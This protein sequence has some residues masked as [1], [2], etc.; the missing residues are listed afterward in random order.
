MGA[1]LILQRHVKLASMKVSHIKSFLANHKHSKDLIRFL[2]LL[3]VLVIYFGYLSWKYDLAT[4]GIVSA[5]TW[6]FFVLCTPI[7]DAGFLIDFPVRL[8][9]GLRMIFTEIGVWILAIGLNIAALHYTPGSY[10]KSFLTN[11]L[12]KII[13]TP[14]PY[15]SIVILCA[16]GTF[17]SIHFGDKVMDGITHHKDL[18]QD[19]ENKKYKLLKLA[20]MAV[21]IVVIIY[22]YYHLIS[23]LGIKIEE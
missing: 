16:L 10:D 5:L 13:T 4:G 18:S 14:W 1:F 6:S 3:S 2:G 17:L 15:G 19:Q 9:T 12:H 11:L 23:R 8:I 22:T 21:L 7:A 20:V